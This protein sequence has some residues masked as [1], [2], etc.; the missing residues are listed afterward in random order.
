MLRQPAKQDLQNMFQTKNP[1]LLQSQFNIKGETQHLAYVRKY[2]QTK[3]TITF[4]ICMFDTTESP[5]NEVEVPIPRKNHQIVHINFADQFELLLNMLQKEVRFIP[6]LMS[7][8]R[9]EYVLRLDQVLD[10]QLYSETHF[11]T[12]RMR[13]LKALLPFF[14]SLSRTPESSPKNIV[15]NQ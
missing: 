7:Q 1:T 11:L 13:F 12:K 8:Q 5:I 9:D 2:I 15:E 4:D 3:N 10:R 6:P 14:G